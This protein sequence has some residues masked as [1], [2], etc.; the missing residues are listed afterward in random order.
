MNREVAQ[1]N[2]VLSRGCEF[3]GKKE[4]TNEQ[5]NE[6]ELPLLGV[7]HDHV[8]SEFKWT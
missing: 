1:D 8:P 3:V 7:Q 4:R 5:I 2:N 6:V